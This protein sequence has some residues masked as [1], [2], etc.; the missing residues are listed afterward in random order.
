MGVLSQ[1]QF[2][3][4][5]FPHSH[6][7][8][9]KGP[10]SFP[11]TG[12]GHLDEFRPYGPNVTADYQTADENKRAFNSPLI[13]ESDEDLKTVYHSESWDTPE[14]EQFEMPEHATYGHTI[15]HMV[16]R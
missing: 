4:A 7:S 12:E 16:P 2:P 15:K 14:S 1:F 13:A 5:Q 11:D 8:H 10:H 6:F 9:V 3:E